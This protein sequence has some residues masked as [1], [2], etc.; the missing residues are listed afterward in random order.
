[1]AQR[2]GAAGRAAVLLRHRLDDYVA[3]VAAVIQRAAV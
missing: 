1:V 2:M 3:K